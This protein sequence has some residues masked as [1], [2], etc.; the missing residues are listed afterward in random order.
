LPPGGRLWHHRRRERCTGTLVALGKGMSFEKRVRDLHKERPGSGGEVSRSL[1]PPP[2]SRGIAG[3]I[4]KWTLL[5]VFTGA[6]LTAGGLAALFYIYGRDLPRVDSLSQYDPPTVTRVYDARGRLMAEYAEDEGYRTFVP[7]AKIPKHVIDAVLA[8]ED[9]DFRQHEGLDYW[10]MLRAFFV[11]LMSGEFRQGGSTITQ[12][13]VKTFLL[14]AERSIPRKIKE[15]ILAR[16]LDQKLSKDEILLLYLNQIYFGHRRYGIEEAARF[17]FGKGVEALALGEAAVLAG[18]I[19]S[20]GRFSPRL[21]PQRAKGRQREVLQSL[22][23]ASAAGKLSRTYTE[24]EVQAAMAAP[25]VLSPPPS[26][27]L[28]AAAYYAD[29]VRQEV[30]GKLGKQ[31]FFRKNLRIETHCDL[32]LQQAAHRALQA[33]LHEIDR[34]RGYRGPLKRLSPSEA[35]SFLSTLE[36]EVQEVAVGEVYRAVVLQAGAESARV[37]LGPVKGTL[38][39]REM[40]WAHPAGRRLQGP[41]RVSDV[42]ASGDVVLVRVV[43]LGSGAGPQAADARVILEQEPQVQGAL[44]ALDPRTRAVRALVGGYEFAKSPF[45]RAVKARRQPGSAFKPVVYSAALRSGRF[46]PATIV[47]D[48]PAVYGQIFD[49]HAYRP[50]NYD[51][52]YRGEVRLRTALAQSLNL[53]AVKVAD[54]IGVEAVRAEAAALGIESPI[55]KGLAVALGADS[56]TPLELANAY[57]VFASGGTWRAPRFIR[58]VLSGDGQVLYAPRERASREAMSPA[59]AY[60]MTSLLRAPIEDPAG[61]AQRARRLGHLVAGK[62]GTT[63]EH[64]DAWFVGFTPE[65]LATVWVGHDDRAPLGRFA[66][67]GRVALPI[68]LSFM[69]EAMR[70]RP[71]SDWPRPAGVEIARIDPRTGL[72]AAPGQLDAIEEVFVAGTSPQQVAPL[73]GATTPETLLLEESHAKEAKPAPPMPTGIR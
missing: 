48:S 26:G 51:R 39:L 59:L 22:L 8:A 49:R 54:D 68:W 31:A 36:K 16:R 1:P 18:L 66:T 37:S 9:A 67:G 65:L 32:T 44:V 38:L 7:L 15:V 33:G 27:S 25:I 4:V 13:V 56:V 21:H 17:Y 46:T 28:S 12:Q 20:P 47:L 3:R 60:V 72:R 35:R 58:R 30:E 62:T 53:V 34:F 71:R 2:H 42:L 23:K 55:S 43:R 5:S 24:A 64:R 63:N 40:R 69:R 57:A 19:K 50:H 14:S 41:R 6:L 45:N 73:P 10:G 70:G 11:N 52:T 61:T 29:L